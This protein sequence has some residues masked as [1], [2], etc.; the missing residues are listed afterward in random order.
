MHGELSETDTNWEN[1]KKKHRPLEFAATWKRLSSSITVTSHGAKTL[2]R[3]ETKYGRGNQNQRFYLLNRPTDSSHIKHMQC[4]KGNVFL[5]LKCFKNNPPIKKSQRNKKSRKQKSRKEKSA[6]C[7]NN[8]PKCDQNQQNHNW[9]KGSQT[10]K[11]FVPSLAVDDVSSIIIHAQ[12]R[13]PTPSKGIQQCWS[14]EICNVGP[15]QALF[16]NF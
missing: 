13:D 2:L 9:L 12:Q 16:S 3:M 7:P 15:L 10:F 4:T 8:F 11:L 14:C 6:K 1:R 5:I